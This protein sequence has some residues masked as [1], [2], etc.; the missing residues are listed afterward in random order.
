MYQ[1]N[2]KGIKITFGHVPKFVLYCRAVEKRFPTDSKE[3]VREGDNE[4]ANP[5]VGIRLCDGNGNVF[6]GFD[7]GGSDGTE[8]NEYR[9]FAVSVRSWPDV[10]TKYSLKDFQRITNPLTVASSCL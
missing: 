9:T 1:S 3:A 5:D 8:R 4:K 10:R 2:Q 7:A 6:S